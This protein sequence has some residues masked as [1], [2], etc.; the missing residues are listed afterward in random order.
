MSLLLHPDS[1]LELQTRPRCSYV[2]RRPCQGL[3]DSVVSQFGNCVHIEISSGFPF[4]CGTAQRSDC[5]GALRTRLVD[6]RL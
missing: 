3:P 5:W 1:G 2:Q 4:L 6:A